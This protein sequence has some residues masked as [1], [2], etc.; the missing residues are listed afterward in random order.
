M[1]FLAQGALGEKIIHQERFRPRLGRAWPAALL[2]SIAP[3]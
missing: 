1:Q 2:V 3:R